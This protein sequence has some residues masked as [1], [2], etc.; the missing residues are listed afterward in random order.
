[1][2]ETLSLTALIATGGATA[3]PTVNTV[4][5][6]YQKKSSKKIGKGAR[7]AASGLST[8]MVSAS[9]MVYD[10]A[11]YDKVLNNAQSYVDSMS[12]EELEAALIA[13]GELEAPAEIEKTNSKTI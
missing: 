7:A 3:Y 9:T 11:H 12:D 1:M 13:I 10:T 6:K 5:D 4:A 8:T 2:I